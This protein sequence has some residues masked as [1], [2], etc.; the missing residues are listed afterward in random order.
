MESSDILESSIQ[1]S[2]SSYPQLI[3]PMNSNIDKYLRISKPTSKLPKNNITMFVGL[4]Y[5]YMSPVISIRSRKKFY[6][7]KEFKL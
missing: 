7:S 3:S 1:S 4:I 6:T 2:L 5:R